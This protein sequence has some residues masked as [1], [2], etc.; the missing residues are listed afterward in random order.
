MSLRTIES[1]IAAGQAEHNLTELQEWVNSGVAWQ[2]EGAVG[3]EAMHHL[4]TGALYLPDVRHVDH[5]GT[6]V[7]S[8]DDL[9][10]GTAGTLENSIR[11]WEHEERSNEEAF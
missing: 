9:K 3:R 5:Y 2:L 8:R 10:P 1:F 4:T 6:V 11:F 7:P